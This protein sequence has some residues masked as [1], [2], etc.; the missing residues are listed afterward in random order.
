MDPNHTPDLEALL[1]ENLRLTRENNKLLKKIHHSHLVDV[2]ARI[3]FL[4]IAV[5]A[6]IFIYQYYLEDYVARFWSS[7]QEF[8]TDLEKI[9]D[10]PSSFI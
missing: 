10:L 1:N 7:Y 2:W 3:L 5:G 6:P 8:R 9:G 4:L